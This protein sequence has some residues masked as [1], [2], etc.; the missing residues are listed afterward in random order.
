MNNHSDPEDKQKWEVNVWEVVTKLIPVLQANP[1]TSRDSEFWS[2]KVD[3]LK[4]KLKL[5]LETVRP[6]KK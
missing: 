6:E 5:C 1:D 2:D 4:R 3:H